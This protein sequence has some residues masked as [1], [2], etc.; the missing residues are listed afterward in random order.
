[1]KKPEYDLRPFIKRALE[2]P[3]RVT[4]AGEQ[5]PAYAGMDLVGERQ[6]F[7]ERR[8]V[9]TDVDRIVKQP[10]RSAPGFHERLHG[11][12]ADRAACSVSGTEIVAPAGKMAVIRCDGLAWISTSVIFSS[13]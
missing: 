6:R 4:L 12:G 1:M 8:D 13:P 11:G 9:F 10:H 3:P 7:D 5:N 2:C